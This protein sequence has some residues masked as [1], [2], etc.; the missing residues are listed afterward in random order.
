MLL[1]AY[2]STQLDFIFYLEV[3]TFINFHRLFL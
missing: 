1:Q 3:S 2:Q